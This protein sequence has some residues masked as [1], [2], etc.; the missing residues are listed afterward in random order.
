MKWTVLLVLV[1]ATV[2]CTHVE[3]KEGL[4]QVQAAQEKVIEEFERGNKLLDEK[5]PA[6]A[7]KVYD[8]LILKY[9][10]NQLDTLIIFN[11][12]LAH[13]QND[14]CA[15][16]AERFRK[17]IRKT[18]NNSPAIHA[19]A[20]LRMSDVYTCLG[21]D[22]KAITSLIAI[23]RASSPLPIE[24]AKAE[25]PAKLAAAYARLG[26][27]K[28][29]AAFFRSAEKGLLELQNSLR[30]PA[31][32]KDTLAKTL[33]LMGNIDQ[34]NTANMT[35]ED[36]L[37]TISALQKYLYKA[38][39]LDSRAWSVQSMEQI[40]R[41]YDGAWAYIDRVQMD[42]STGD[43]GQAQQKKKSEQVRVAQ[44]TLQAIKTLY[45]E[46]VP[47]PEEPQVVSDLLK[48][49]KTHETRLRNYIAT[50]IVGTALTPEALEAEGIKRAGRVLNPDPI[51]EQK[52]QKKA[53]AA[54]KKP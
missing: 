19:R 51:L 15:T 24:I 8:D 4:D 12:G 49:M 25:I 38:V 5:N 43:A 21:E 3:E 16:A 2:S 45:M 52:A 41:A 29:A 33:F 47:D 31:V 48:K 7:A 14:D 50:N 32:R 1:A 9:P 40:S 28:Q 42:V 44:Q 26:N 20:Q 37:A 10:T 11:S 22:S 23:H 6:E 17:V 53:K 30:D 36:Y 39:E 54:K 18:A 46:R 27:N 35:A 34:V 13:M